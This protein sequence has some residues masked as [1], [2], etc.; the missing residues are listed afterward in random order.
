MRIALTSEPVDE[1]V[2]AG[3]GGWDGTGEFEEGE[4]EDYLFGVGALS[5]AG[6][7]RRWSLT[8]CPWMWPAGPRRPPPSGLRA[9]G[10]LYRP[11]PRL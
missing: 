10:R 1:A 4:I 6:V 7:R 11:Y 3:V 9:R 5:E 2:F 8:R